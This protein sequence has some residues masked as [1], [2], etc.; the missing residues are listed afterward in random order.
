MRHITF[1]SFLAENE[2][3][4]IYAEKF[5]NAPAWSPAVA[6]FEYQIGPITFSARKGLGSVPLNGNI[7]HEGAVAL[8]KP[9]T[10]LKLALDDEGHQEPT[11]YEL[12]ELVVKQGYAVGIPFLDIRFDQKGESLPKVTGHEGRGRMRMI[13]RV[14]GDDPIPV[15]LKLTGG[16]RSSDLYKNK[17]LIDELKQGLFAQAGGLIRGAV[18]KIFV[19]ADGRNNTPGKEL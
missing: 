8:M 10:F 1:K 13:K 11:S 6:E 4:K 14:L 3:R 5:E 18:E 15:H 17:E 9:S 12:E 16:M 2:P 7:W 19:S